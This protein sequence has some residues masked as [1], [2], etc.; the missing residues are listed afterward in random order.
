MK[1]GR[2]RADERME[3]ARLML[4]MLKINR[5]GPFPGFTLI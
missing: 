3:K 5:F 4:Y 1:K 2:Q